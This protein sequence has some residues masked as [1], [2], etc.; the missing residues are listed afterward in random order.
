MFD[1]FTTIEPLAIYLWTMVCLSWQSTEARSSELQSMKFLSSTFLLIGAVPLHRSPH[2]SASWTLESTVWIPVLARHS[3]QSTGSKTNDVLDS[4]MI[5]RSECIAI[6]S[7]KTDEVSGDSLDPVILIRPNLMRV[8]K[9]SGGEIWHHNSIVHPLASYW[10]PVPMLN[11]N[12][13]RFSSLDAQTGR[14]HSS[15]N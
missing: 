13:D 4:S 9:D 1:L 15:S 14:N 2:R 6:C 10:T 12:I 8:D 3:I 11:V 5:K 7:T